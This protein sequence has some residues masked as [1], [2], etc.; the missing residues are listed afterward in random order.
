MSLDHDAIRKAYPNVV[1]IDN[2][3]SIIRYKFGND[4]EV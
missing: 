4:V 1:L 2:V 3:G